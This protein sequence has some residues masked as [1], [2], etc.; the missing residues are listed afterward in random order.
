M[1][2]FYLILSSYSG[3]GVVLAFIIS[4]HE[5]IPNGSPCLWEIICSRDYDRR[6]T[7]RPSFPRERGQHYNISH[8]A[9]ISLA[10]VDVA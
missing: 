8:T 3:C 10:P 7:V 1:I 2:V 4:Q 5:D 6:P 9:R